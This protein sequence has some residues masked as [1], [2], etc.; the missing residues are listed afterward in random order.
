M[1]GLFLLFLSVLI[2]VIYLYI[3][4]HDIPYYLFYHI[5]LFKYYIILPITIVLPFSIDAILILS[6]DKFELF[7]VIL[8][9]SSFHLF[10]C[11]QIRN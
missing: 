1:L 5:P 4:L 3:D 2:L 8:F 6:I 11:P 9:V 7:A 10:A